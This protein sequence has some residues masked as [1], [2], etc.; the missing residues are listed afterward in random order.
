MTGISS[1]PSD[2]VVGLFAELRSTPLT[3]GVTTLREFLTINDLAAV[4]SAV[5]GIRAVVGAGVVGAAV[6]GVV[7][8]STIVRACARIEGLVVL[9]GVEASGPEGQDHGGRGNERFL[10]KF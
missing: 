5:P 8:R 7:R 6:R 4:G 2:V 10:V 3:Q 1:L 9:V